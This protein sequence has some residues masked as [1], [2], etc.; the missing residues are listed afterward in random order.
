MN[1]YMHASPSVEKEAMDLNKSFGR[2]MGGLGQRK[3][4]GEAI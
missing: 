2:N 1:T 3:E 4:K